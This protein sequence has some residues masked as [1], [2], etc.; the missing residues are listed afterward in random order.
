M[1][2]SHLPPV[3]LLLVIV[4]RTLCLKCSLDSR[5]G[6]AWNLEKLGAMDSKHGSVRD[7]YSKLNSCWFYFKLSTSCLFGLFKA[8]VSFSVSNDLSAW[9]N[10]ILGS[11]GPQQR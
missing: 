8:P 1:G 11:M 4:S 3:A 6:M 9:V 7:F 10:A 5:L 2:K